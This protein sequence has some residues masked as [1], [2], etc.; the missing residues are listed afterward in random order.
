MLSKKWVYQK[1]LR[2]LSQT[3]LFLLQ[4]QQGSARFTVLLERQ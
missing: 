1:H 3:I 4:E 2:I